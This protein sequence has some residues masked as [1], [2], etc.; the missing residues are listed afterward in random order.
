[1]VGPNC[2]KANV[3]SVYGD[4]LIAISFNAMGRLQ[5]DSILYINDHGSILD[6]Q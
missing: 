3:Y 6:T 4:I 2:Y 1:M 5:Q